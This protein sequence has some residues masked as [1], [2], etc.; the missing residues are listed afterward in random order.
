[1]RSRLLTIPATGGEPKQVARTEGKLTF[2]RWSPDGNWIAWLGATSMDDP[3]AG[4]VFVVPA[5]G[6]TAENLLKGY[7]RYC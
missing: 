6:G 3:F 5:T 7:A 1:M 2:P 4:S